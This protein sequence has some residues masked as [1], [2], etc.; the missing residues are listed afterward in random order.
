MVLGLLLQEPIHP[1]M[2]RLAIDSMPQKA[3]HILG[4]QPF[5]SYP[6]SRTS[7]LGS[8]LQKPTS[9]MDEQAMHQET[10]VRRKVDRHLL[11]ILCWLSIVVS[12]DAINI[13]NARLENLEQDLHM[14]GQMFNIAI[15]VF[16]IPCILC[17]IPANILSQAS[18]P[19]FYTGSLT[20]ICGLY[21]HFTLLTAR[22]FVD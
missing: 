20:V 21:T 18:K 17:S 11:P 15:M 8:T 22:R 7:S 2:N 12:L 16:Y 19:S 4:L 10:R 9:E 1:K 14:H 6:S 13:G 5:D 3:A